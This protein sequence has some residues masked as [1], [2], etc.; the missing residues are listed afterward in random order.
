MYSVV[1]QDALH[2][3][4]MGDGFSAEPH[5][6][7]TRSATALS[8]CENPIVLL[9]EHQMVIPKVRSAHVPVKLLG[10]EVKRK[11]IHQDSVHGCSHFLSRLR[12]EVGWC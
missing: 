11:D 2:T 12:I 5:P 9:V 6:F 7:R 10:V 1:I 3:D 4:N 8:H